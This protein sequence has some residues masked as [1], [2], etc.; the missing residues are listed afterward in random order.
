M[1]KRVPAAIA[2]F[3]SIGVQGFTR[4]LLGRAGVLKRQGWPDS[5][6]SGLMSQRRGAP[7]GDIDRAEAKGRLRSQR[8]IT[9]ELMAEGAQAGYIVPDCQQ[10]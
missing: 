9:S 4:E 10:T 2:A 1:S 5:G 6:A 8:D 7:E 3:N